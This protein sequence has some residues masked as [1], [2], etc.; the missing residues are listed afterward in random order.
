MKTF[1]IIIALLFIFETG[2][3][4]V[5]IGTVSPDPSAALDISASGKG[6][7]VPRITLTQRTGI[8]SPAQGLVVYQTD[9][10]PGFYYNAG[11][12]STPSW[13]IIES[14][15]FT[16]PSSN[17]NAGELLQSNGDGTTSWSAAGVPAGTVVPYAGITAPTGWAL[18]YGQALSRSLY[19]NLF[20]I[21]ATTYGA[22]DG[23]TTFNL[24]DLR[25]RLIYG[26]DDM[27]GVAANTIIT[28]YGIDGS[29][30]GAGGGSQNRTL[31]IAEIPSHSHSVN[32]TGTTDTSGTHTHPYKDAYFAESGGNNAYGSNV[33]GLS[34]G[35]D[36]DNNF[37]FRSRSNTHIITPT[38]DVNPLTAAGGV[39]SHTITLSGVTGNSGSGTAFSILNPGRILNY[40]I[41]L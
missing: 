35:S 22:G 32:L 17:G 41:K 23:S 13:L 7:L 16:L 18:C 19:S 10:I 24:P 29:A 5:G 4:Q 3:A 6:I 14:A 2:N 15:T 27:G 12:S 9:G 28:A 30:L 38:D 39:H 40:L 31:S 33:Y 8:A 26:K 34:S 36:F 1:K 11:T 20:S 21:V 25:G 37:R